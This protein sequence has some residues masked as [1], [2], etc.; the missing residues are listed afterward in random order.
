MLHDWQICSLS[1]QYTDH[2]RFREERSYYSTIYTF[3]AIKMFINFHLFIV[4]LHTQ[5]IKDLKNDL[6]FTVP[7]LAKAL[8]NSFWNLLVMDKKNMN[9]DTFTTLL[10]RPKMSIKRF[11]QL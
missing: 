6:H 11:K 1:F 4:Y 7:S 10:K 8:L 2:A 3:R 9:T 5:N